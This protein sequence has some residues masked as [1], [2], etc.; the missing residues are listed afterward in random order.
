MIQYI[1]RIKFIHII[2]FIYIIKGY[3]KLY[4][5]MNIKVNE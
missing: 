4:P 5:T 1:T 3:E 2:F